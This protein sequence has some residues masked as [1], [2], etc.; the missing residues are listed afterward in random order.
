MAA[1]PLPP[2]P[3]LPLPPKISEPTIGNALVKAL[4]KTIGVGSVLAFN[5]P[6]RSAPAPVLTPQYQGISWP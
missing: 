1:L 3:L 4:L 2:P 6:S 5:I